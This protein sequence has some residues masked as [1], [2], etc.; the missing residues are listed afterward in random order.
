MYGVLVSKHPLRRDK[1]AGGGK[2]SRPRVLSRAVREEVVC[3]WTLQAKN[4]RAEMPFS[5]APC[6][7]PAPLDIFSNG[8]RTLRAR[9]RTGGLLSPSHVGVPPLGGL[10]KPAKAGTPACC[11]KAKRLFCLVVNKIDVSRIFVVVALVRA[12]LRLANKHRGRANGG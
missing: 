9:Q 6:P 11:A 3:E 8:Y 1:P 5:I 12:D 10:L 7:V 4:H 2:K